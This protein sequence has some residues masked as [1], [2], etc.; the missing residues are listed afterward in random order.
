VKGLTALHPEVPAEQRGKYLGLA[1]EPVIA[2]LKSLGVTALELLPSQQGYSER[3]L[4]ERGLCNYWGY[5]TLGFFAPDV[6]FASNGGGA[7]IDEFKTMV[8]ALH[9]AGIEV[10][11]DVVY[12]HT[13][14]AEQIGPTLCFR[15]VDNAAYYM[16]DPDDRRRYLD[17]TGCGNTVNVT[18]PQV[19]RLVADSLR[20]WVQEMHVDGFRFDLAPALGRRGRAAPELDQGLFALIAQDPVL[21]RV[22][23]IAEP[24]DVGHDGMRLGGFL[25]GFAEWNSRYR[26]TARRGFLRGDSGMIGE[27]ATRLAG[28]SD[29]FAGAGRAPQASVNFVACHDGF[30]LHD[31][32]AYE[33]KHNDENG[34][35]S[36]D[37]D[38]NNHSRNFGIEGE[39]ERAD[40]RD[41]REPAARGLLGL[42][43][44][45][46]GTPM[47][48]QGDE[49]GRSQ[50][51]NNNPYNQDSAPFWVSW[52]LDAGGRA[53]L[54]HA[55][56]CFALR[57]ELGLFRRL[58]HLSAG[59]VQ[60]LRPEGG[61]LEAADWHAP[62]RRALG[63]RVRGHD[64]NGKPDA[65][66]PDTL[67]LLNAG[68]APLH[69][70]LPRDARA[71]AWSV[72]A[73]SAEPV[74]APDAV[75]LD[76]VRVGAHG[77][78]ML[79]ALRRQA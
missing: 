49:F 56:R 51:G 3:F 64:A 75:A 46:L 19:L 57:R 34:W 7:Q 77:V 50:G 68:D 6:R 21:S 23:L 2:H 45:S 4:V 59:D 42:L 8:R 79:I 16:L 15:G 58:A 5:N 27:L 39:T 32:T 36:Q 67:L 37:G 11:L 1:S 71:H 33:R 40:V 60:W 48:Q 55:R 35:N 54:E 73:D 41:A 31:L 65:S 66:A 9:R 43:A 76:S 14:E 38:G 72:R 70:A 47:L 12:N 69:F 29:L 22:K 28:S 53:M 44:F 62:A 52:Q 10:I 26:D 17:F 61:E 20:Y 63:M 13:G 18:H 30:T 25:P 74:L 24:W 78:C